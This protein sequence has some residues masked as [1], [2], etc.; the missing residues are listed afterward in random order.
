[1]LSIGCG[2]G[3]EVWTLR[4]LFPN[5]I[6]HG[7]DIDSEAIKEAQQT[8]EEYPTIDFLCRKEDLWTDY[9]VVWCLSVA[10]CY[11]RS[12]QFSFA[13]FERFMTDI[14]KRVA[15]GGF[16]VIYNAQYD[17]STVG[18]AASYVPVDIGRHDS[19]VVP[20][21]RPNGGALGPEFWVPIL[22]HKSVESWV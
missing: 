3:D 15:P 10:C 11:P 20:K 18:A 2:P 16:L 17:F 7:Y 19:G 6:I 21:F 22:F 4:E 5:S 12:E 1:M 14:D 9:D 8:N 13:Q